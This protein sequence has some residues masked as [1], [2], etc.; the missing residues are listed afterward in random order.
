MRRSVSGNVFTSFNDIPSQRYSL[1]YIDP[2]FKYYG[3][4]NKDQAAGKHYDCMTVDEMTNAFDV[5]RIVTPKRNAIAVWAMVPQLQ[6][7][8]I[9]INNWGFYY[10]G[11]LKVWVKCTKAGK[12]IHG[13]GV[14]ATAVKNEV[15]LLLLGSTQKY[16]R[17]LPIMIENAH[18]TIF[19]P[20]GEHSEKPS[21]IRTQLVELFGDVPRIEIFS[22]QAVEGWD[23]FGN[24]VKSQ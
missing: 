13:A 5:K 20:K 12:V 14:R 17:P 9:L 15:E 19:E 1:A 16:G 22:R 10:R 4:P 24:Q 18:Q 6:N 11:I 2:P 3:D 23:S 21:I 8:I 7:A